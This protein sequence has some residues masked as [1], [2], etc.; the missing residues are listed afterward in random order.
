MYSNDYK[1]SPKSNRLQVI[2]STLWKKLFLGF[3]FSPFSLVFF[4]FNQ[5]LEAKI[6]AVFETFECV[7]LP[8]DSGFLNHV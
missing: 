7:S 4:L 3:S 6:S 1:M 2:T 5:V 8:A